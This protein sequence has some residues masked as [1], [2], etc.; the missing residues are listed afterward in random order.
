MA[1]IRITVATDGPKLDVT[2]MIFWG[3]LENS[4]GKILGV[5]LYGK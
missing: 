2:W 1:I 3:G 4:V 5:I